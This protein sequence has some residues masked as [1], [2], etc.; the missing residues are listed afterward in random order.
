M[1]VRLSAKQ[2]IFFISPRLKD[3][4]DGR[5]VVI[6]QRHLERQ[7][8]ELSAT[9]ATIATIATMPRL[10]AK[11]PK[12]PRGF[13]VEQIGDFVLSGDKTRGGGAATKAVA[14]LARRAAEDA[15]RMSTKGG[16]TQ[17]S[18]RPLSEYPEGYFTGTRKALEDKTKPTDIFMACRFKVM[19]QR[20]IAARFDLPLSEEERKTEDSLRAEGEPENPTPG[21]ASRLF[22]SEDP[23]RWQEAILTARAS[24]IKPAKMNVLEEDSRLSQEQKDEASALIHVAVQYY[25]PRPTPDSDAPDTTMFDAEKHEIDFSRLTESYKRD[26]LRFSAR[27]IWGDTFEDE[28]NEGEPPAAEASAVSST[29]VSSDDSAVVPAVLAMLPGSVGSEE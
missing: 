21:V 18:P 2:C 26:E 28:T 12:V 5:R 27:P 10:N 9:Y 7:E 25:R 16:T 11:I 19:R 13:A 17:A 3:F 14:F 6:I 15:I 8:Q 29:E 24:I 23:Q 1:L 22:S 20:R 4:G